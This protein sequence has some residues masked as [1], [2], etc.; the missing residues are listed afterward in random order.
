[1]NIK[2][3]EM[4]IRNFKGA[5]EF[6][7]KPGGQN[8]EV[9]GQMGTGKSTLYDAFWFALFGKNSQGDTKFQ[10]KPKDK[11]NQ[12]IHHL[13]TEVELLLQ[14]NGEEVSLSRVV[15]ENW[16]RKTGSETENYEGDVTTCRIN[17][18]KKKVSDFKKYID[19][20]ID[21]ETFKQLTNVYYFSDT[22]NDKERRKMLFELVGNLSDEDVIASKK[23]LSD[24]TYLLNG[25]SVDDKREQWLEDKAKTKAD[26]KEWDI[27]IDEA[28]RNIPVIDGLDK[29][30]LAA[31]KA[32]LLVEKNDVEQQ[33][34]MILNGGFVATKRAELMQVQ[35]KV[36]EAR[37]THAIKQNESLS[38][39]KSALQE[40]QSKKMDVSS[41]V[42]AIRYAM[43]DLENEKSR[44]QDTVKINEREMVRLR[45]EY[46]NVHSR[47][48]EAL[49][50][51]LLVCH[52]CKRAYEEEQQEQIKAAYQDETK[53]FNAEKASRLESV[54]LKGKSLA[55]KNKALTEE[56]AEL[57]KRLSI[58]QGQLEVFQIDLDIL[59]AEIAELDDQ[60]K[61]AKQSA[62]PFESS[63]EHAALKVEI[64]K[65]QSEIENEQE[66]AASFREGLQDSL[67]EIQSGIA[68]V[69]ESLAKFETL[70]KAT[71]RK[72]QLIQEQKEKTIRAGEIEK[73]LFLLDE[74]TRTK[75]SLL[76][77]RINSQFEIT[78][79]KL[80]EPLQNGSLKEVC[81]PLFKGLEFT[82]AIS[83]G[84]R[85]NVG[86]DIINTISRLQGISVPIFVDNA[87][88]VT[89]WHIKPQ[90]QTVSL[91]AKIGQKTLKIAQNKE[92]EVA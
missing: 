25:A 2:L 55:D 33:I 30:A 62:E 35:A 1:M 9:F 89:I 38:A 46:T 13:E 5:R 18:V 84:E 76:T 77:D 66:Q 11:D 81:V 60:I 10:W 12:P 91:I 26:I 80:F 63:K 90:S 22:M 8:V 83:N 73:Q 50:E 23:E 79:F 17:G 72:E 86:V 57:D 42:K 71:K 85:V 32:A 56:I 82:G 52:T 3:L 67:N 45:E 36:Q 27:R 34:S 48:M 53:T 92:T 68:S 65:I 59:S 4:K 14:V 19:S 58:A 16:V 41:E 29:D 78:S 69:N 24:L 43:G 61:F 37:S 39:L 31:E 49:D 15:S 75:V 88:S 64:D 6:E 44:K 20:L 7:F 51:H 54:S 28:D 70:D 74:F 40:N 47:K 87:E 21:E